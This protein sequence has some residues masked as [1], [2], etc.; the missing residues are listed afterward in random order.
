MNKETETKIYRSAGTEGTCPKCFS[1]NA[2]LGGSDWDG[3]KL[4]P[5]VKCRDCG[6][7]VI[8]PEVIEVQ[9]GEL[10][11][12]YK[13]GKDNQEVDLLVLQHRILKAQKRVNILQNMYRKQT[14][15][16]FHG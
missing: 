16:N 5:F 2:M 10:I 8:E 3:E 11:T 7:K 13:D 15:K 4:T 1:G 6:F 14:G 12:R 9:Y